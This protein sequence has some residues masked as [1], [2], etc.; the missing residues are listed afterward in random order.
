MGKCSLVC[1]RQRGEHE[2]NREGTAKGKGE[3][4][5]VE[6]ARTF[7][8]MVMLDRSARGYRS[9]LSCLLLLPLLISLLLLLFSC[10]HRNCESRSSEIS[11]TFT[12]EGTG[13]K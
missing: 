6:S 2:K 4:E 10:S 5:G 7:K 9:R 8:F 3:G 11:R 1:G 12:G 13:R